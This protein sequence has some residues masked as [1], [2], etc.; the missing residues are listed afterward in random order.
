MSN[1][2]KFKS[3]K[4]QSE[5]VDHDEGDSNGES[6]DF[7]FSGLKSEWIIFHELLRAKIQDKLHDKGTRFLLSDAKKSTTEFDIRSVPISYDGLQSIEVVGENKNVKIMQ[8]STKLKKERREEIESVEK[9]NKEIQT[10][11]RNTTQIIRL[12]CNKT[13]QS[14]L[15]EFNG[16]PIKSYEYLLGKFGPGSQGP[17]DQTSSFLKLMS[18]KM[19]HEDMFS[20]FEIK[21]EKLRIYCNFPKPLALTFIQSNKNSNEF[22]MQMLPD[23]LLDDVQQTI[24][25]QLNYDAA[26]EY[27]TQ[28][29]NLQHQSKIPKETRTGSVSMIKKYNKNEDN[30]KTFCHKPNSFC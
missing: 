14:K 15:L 8:L 16:D 1:Y 17:Q 5:F 12:L 22:N 11:E 19:N 24:K 28:R 10:I 3:K 6:E 20:N 25:N 18:M 7:T 4:F 9:R 30:N 29:D 21:F 2:N 23:R 27:L 26:I 13:I